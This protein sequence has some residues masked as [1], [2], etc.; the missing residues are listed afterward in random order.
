MITEMNAVKNRTGKGVPR[1]GVILLAVLLLACTLMAGAVSAVENNYYNVPVGT[2]WEGYNIT[3]DF[4]DSSDNRVNFTDFISAINYARPNVSAGEEAVF[5]CKP[6]TVIYGAVPPTPAKDHP[7]VNFSFTIYGNGA[8]IAYSPAFP[9]KKFDFS[10]DTS[11][12]QYEPQLTSDI[13]MNVYNLTNLTFWGQKSTSHTVNIN[14]DRCTYNGI[15]AIM[16][17]TND[18]TGLT[19]SI[20]IAIKNSALSD[21]TD[22]L[23]HTIHSGT[24]NIETCTFTNSPAPVNI[25]YKGTNGQVKLIVNDCS[26]TNCGK[27]TSDDMKLYSAPI[28][29]VNNVADDPNSVS[30]EITGCSF[31]NQESSNGD[32]LLGDGRD[33]K[34]SKGI[35]ATIT[36]LQTDAN[37]Q[38]QN[39]GER[40]STGYTGYTR[41][42]SEGTNYVVS[43][44]GSGTPTVDIILPPQPEPQ[45]VILSSGDGNMNNAYRVLFLDGASTVTV[46]TDLSS[47]DHV[48]K[49]A[50][51]VKDGFTFAG[52]YKDEA[53]THEWD[54]TEGIPGDMSLHAKWTASGSSQ[55]TATAEPTAKATAE[56]TA[57]PTKAPATTAPTAVTTTAAPV[58]T[59]EPGSQPTLTQA[60]APVLGTLLGLLAAGVLIRRRD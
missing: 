14:I 23:V 5:Y 60:P 28:R 30:V 37:I 56:Q 18:V 45:P 41:D 21:G 47:G 33:G 46:I 9:Q 11:G 48:A 59:T 55:T 32:I 4:R 53:C 27:G 40:T 8:T 2:T 12:S 24:V 7:A 6:E 25:A 34:T 43:H 3:S 54:F 50:D 44:T 26:F 19:G 13:T 36:D 22:S 57:E 38:V 29:A 10:I 17:R 49:P 31:D 1:Q 52:W 42:L 51:P 20:N 15:G 35:T 16:F 39:P 58:S